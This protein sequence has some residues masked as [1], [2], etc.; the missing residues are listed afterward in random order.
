MCLKCP[1]SKSFILKSAD[2][3]QKISKFCLDLQ[4]FAKC[5]AL[6]FRLCGFKSGLKFAYVNLK[7][8]LD[9]YVRIT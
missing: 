3:S 1:A 5:T 7:F 4:Y 6:D 2:F 9:L 8:D